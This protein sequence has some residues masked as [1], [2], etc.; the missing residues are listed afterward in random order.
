MS[1]KSSW[2]VL[3]VGMVEGNTHSNKPQVAGKRQIIDLLAGIPSRLRIAQC[4]DSVIF[5]QDDDII[6]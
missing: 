3:P 1:I 5:M 4:V 6:V 2:S